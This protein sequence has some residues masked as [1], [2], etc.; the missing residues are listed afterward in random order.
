[1][2]VARI[3]Y[4]EDELAGFLRVLTPPPEAWIANAQRAIRD[5]LVSDGHRSAS[6]A[7]QLSELSRAL[8]RDPQLRQSF[9]ADPVATAEVAGWPELAR[10]LEREMREL[11][12]LAERITAD[13]AYRMSL[14]ADPTGVLEAAGVPSAAA[15]PVL[16]A[17]AASGEVLA[18]V[19]EVVAHQ[20]DEQSIEATLVLLL[21]EST[22]V[23]AKLRDATSR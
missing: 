15:E 6:P 21:L 12:A 20:H 7:R 16:R 8:D 1:L 23:L 10:E 18:R 17:L 9:D 3:P 22:A 5:L 13:A 4:T 19:P 14:D 2:T 11:V